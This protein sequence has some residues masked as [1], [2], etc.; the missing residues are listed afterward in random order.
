MKDDVQ[1]D[2]QLIAR[3]F[4]KH[5]E[6]T[7]EQAS[8]DLAS[9]IGSSSTVERR[10]RKMKADALLSERTTI[11]ELG[12]AR[13]CLPVPDRCAPGPGSFARAGVLRSP[14]G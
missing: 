11:I 9:A 8:H 5:P 4:L 12:G 2:Y 3:Y 7:V 10:I 6:A 13:L 14:P 1:Q